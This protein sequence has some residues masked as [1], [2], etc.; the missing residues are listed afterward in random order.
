MKEVF[1]LSQFNREAIKVDFS[2]EY[3]YN[4]LFDVTQGGVCFKRRKGFS[5][6]SENVVSNVE[7]G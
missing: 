4:Q 2:N 6:S 3:G 1:R 7:A 5:I